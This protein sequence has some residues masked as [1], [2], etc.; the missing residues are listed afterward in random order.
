[1][2]DRIRLTIDNGVADVRLNQ[3]DKMK[4]LDPEMFR[5]IA[6]AGARLRRACLL[7][8]TAV[9]L[10]MLQ[11]RNAANHSLRPQPCGT[12]PRCGSKIG[13][14]SST[15]RGKGRGPREAFI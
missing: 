12:G 2:A 15:G 6:E 11:L 4:A 10:A 9:A 14:R 13:S 7:N 3:A 5:A 8:L 1:M